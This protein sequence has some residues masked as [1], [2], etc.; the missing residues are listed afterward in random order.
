MLLVAHS[1]AVAPEPAGEPVRVRRFRL[2]RVRVDA[3]VAS[4]AVRAP[5][6]KRD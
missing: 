5:E 4:G 2:A 6:V 3:G 1:R